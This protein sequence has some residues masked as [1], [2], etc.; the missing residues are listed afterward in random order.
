MEESGVFSPGFL[1][2]V[3]C[4]LWPYLLTVTMVLVKVPETDAT[5]PKTGLLAPSS[6]YQSLC[7][8]LFQVSRNLNQVEERTYSFRL[9][10]DRKPL[11]INVA[12]A[13][14]LNRILVFFTRQTATLSGESKHLMVSILTAA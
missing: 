13:N 12:A 8:M 5:A 7:R 1:C 6:I 4:M 11:S 14:P 10:S 2:T 9:V 3:W